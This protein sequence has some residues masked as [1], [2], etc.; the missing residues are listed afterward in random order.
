MRKALAGFNANTVIIMLVSALLCYMQ[1]RVLDAVWDVPA[2]VL[3]VN[4]LQL[5]LDREERERKEADDKKD[6]QIRMLWEANRKHQ[7][8]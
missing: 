4:D 1:K 5:K 6:Q 7:Q 3:K 2:L 8:P